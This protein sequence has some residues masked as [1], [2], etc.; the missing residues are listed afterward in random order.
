LTDIQLLKPFGKINRGLVR[1]DVAD[2][3]PQQ[4]GQFVF[5]LRKRDDPAEDINAAARRSGAST[6]KNR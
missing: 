3:M 5:I 2:L 1:A 6:M 4:G